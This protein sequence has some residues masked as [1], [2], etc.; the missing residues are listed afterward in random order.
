MAAEGDKHWRG[1]GPH[2]LV[3]PLFPRSRFRDASAHATT[4]LVPCARTTPPTVKRRKTKNRNEDRS[5][6]RAARGI[7]RRAWGSRSRPRESARSCDGA[8]AARR[9]G[10]DAP[11]RGDVRPPPSAAFPFLTFHL[12]FCIAGLEE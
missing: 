5:A 3:E 8:P 1:E 10:D 4:P 12:L 6:L 2:R 11:C 9:R 7:S